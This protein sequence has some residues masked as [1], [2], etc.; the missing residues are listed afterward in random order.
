MHRLTFIFGFSAE[1]YLMASVSPQEMFLCL[2]VLCSGVKQKA[3]SSR[4][5]NFFISLT[6][7]NISLPLLRSSRELNR[8]V[9]A[10]FFCPLSIDEHRSQELVENSS[11]VELMTCSFKLLFI[12][13]TSM[14]C[15]HTLSEQVYKQTWGSEKPDFKPVLD[16]LWVNKLNPLTFRL[17]RAEIS[18][19]T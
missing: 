11:E 3:R 7:A 10:P 5:T 19:R 8:L 9:Q 4:V 2:T 16:L 18:P 17:I 6:L 13:Q 1:S 12:F 15:P 14:L